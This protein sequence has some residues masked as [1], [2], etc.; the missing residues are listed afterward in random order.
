VL[1]P[2][3]L[4]VSGAVLHDQQDAQDASGI[5]CTVLV[6]L[7][8]CVRLMTSTVFSRCFEVT[9]LA[10]MQVNCSAAQAHSAQMA[11]SRFEP[12]YSRGSTGPSTA[13]AAA[14]AACGSTAAGRRHQDHWGSRWARWSPCSCPKS[15]PGCPRSPEC[16]WDSD[17][18]DSNHNGDAAVH[19]EG[20]GCAAHG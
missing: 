14:A 8:P 16:T 9:A 18:S 17:P 20:P 19:S 10:H 12:R 13:G 15:R 1:S 11:H 6:M 7:C 5:C 3:S 4:R 2:T